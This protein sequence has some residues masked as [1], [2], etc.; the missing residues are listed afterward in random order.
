MHYPSAVEPV[1]KRANKFSVAAYYLGRRLSEGYRGA[2]AGASGKPALIS[3]PR[4]K[5]D[6][7]FA[8]AWSNDTENTIRDA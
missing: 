6:K 7:A 4:G 3:A 5:G 8:V 2:G 1:R